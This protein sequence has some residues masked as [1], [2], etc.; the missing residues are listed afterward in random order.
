LE[1][2]KRGEHTLMSEEEFMEQL[3]AEGLA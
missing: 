3:K 2:S 1:R